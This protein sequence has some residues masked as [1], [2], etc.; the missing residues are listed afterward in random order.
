MDGR[1]AK[2]SKRGKH[3]FAFLRADRL[4]CLRLRGGRRDQKRAVRRLC[5]DTESNYF[6]E[7]LSGIGGVEFHREYMR[8][9][10][11][12]HGPIRFDCGVVYD[13]ENQ[14]YREFRND[15]ANELV[16]VLATANELISHSGQRHDLLVL[17][18][19]CGEDRVAPLWQIAHHD[20]FDLCNWASL[21]SLAR[22]YVPEERLDAYNRAWENR[23]K[24][25]DVR[26]PEERPGWR[27]NQHFIEWQL[28]KARFDVERTY[29]VFNH[30]AAQKCIESLEP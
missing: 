17:E 11:A 13:E 18:Q 26:W 8:D 15:Q 12:K 29:A 10:V 21:D 9:W 1:H 4:S 2:K 22:Q 5:F 23:R 20:L 24:Q 25:A 16:A 6:K 14:E 30:L 19:V 3:D 27:P 7:P 28:A